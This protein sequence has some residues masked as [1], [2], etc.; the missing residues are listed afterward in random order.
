M[1]LHLAIPAGIAAVALTSAL[2]TIS[3]LRSSRQPRFHY[4]AHPLSDADYGTLAAKPGWR[5]HR[6]SVSPSVALRALLREP[7]T[8]AGP[9]ILFFNG[10][11]AQMLSEGQ[12]VLD[13]LCTERGWGGVVWAYRAFDSSGG[14]PSPA[15]IEDD[16]FKVYTEL[17]TGQKILPDA[18]HLVGFSLGTSIAAAVAARACRRPPASLTLL[19][20]FTKLYL[21]KRMQLFLHRY[22]TSK[23]LDEIASPVLVIHGSLDATLKVE[24]GRAVA[25]T[26]GS[27]ATLLELPEL[28]HCELPTSPTALDAM[29]AF[30][31][32]HAAESASQRTAPT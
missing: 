10:N 31:T 29:R 2:G 26:L 7:A 22:E 9:W 21:G 5:K 28:G 25:K 20:P 14:T 18:V 8:P 4:N 16:G 32:R 19:A 15:A 11:S 17:L 12:H 6:F 1:T 30:I 23:W 27:R 3:L 24:G 13:A